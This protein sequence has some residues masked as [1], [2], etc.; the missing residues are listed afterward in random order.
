MLPKRLE[1]VFPLSM[2]EFLQLKAF[3][4]RVAIRPRTTISSVPVSR[5]QLE[6][7]SDAKDAS[8][9]F[10]ALDSCADLAE[11]SLTGC[12]NVIGKRRETTIV[13]RS[14]LRDG[15]NRSRLKNAIPHLRCGFNPWI[16][17]INYPDKNGVVWFQQL[18]DNP[19]HTALIRLARHLQIEAAHV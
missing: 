8:G 16:N 15:Q 7:S 9:K 4:V 14:E 10:R 18:A 1:T 17:W 2:D 6:V 19:Q 11:C 13:R 5:L 3:A 12:R